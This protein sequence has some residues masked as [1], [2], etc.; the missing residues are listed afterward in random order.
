VFFL[1]MQDTFPNI[2]LSG[3]GLPL[4]AISCNNCGNTHMIN[5]LSLGLD[6]VLKELREAQTKEEEEVE[7]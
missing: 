6:N 7:K 4:V 1:V 3:K 5:L 2:Q